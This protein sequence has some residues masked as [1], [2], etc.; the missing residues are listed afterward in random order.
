MGVTRR[1]RSRR[2]RA[3]SR[4]PVPTARGFCRLV[5]R[6]RLPATVSPSRGSLRLAGRWLTPQRGHR[7]NLNTRR[8]SQSDRAPRSRDQHPCTRARGTEAEAPQLSRDESRSRPPAE[9]A[10]ET[11]RPATAPRSV[12]VCGPGLTASRGVCSVPAARHVPGTGTGRPPRASLNAILL[13]QFLSSTKAAEPGQGRGRWTGAA[14]C[15][16]EAPRPPLGAEP[17]T[18]EP[19]PCTQSERAPCVLSQVLVTLENRGSPVGR[20]TEPVPGTRGDVGGLLWQHPRGS[21]DTSVNRF[22]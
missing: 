10:R 14:D 4:G 16:E 21:R 7:P 3:G 11:R 22:I 20:V 9:L 19:S 15:P 17:P 12:P 5:L 8:T 2:G 6:R 13:F 18:R 1:G